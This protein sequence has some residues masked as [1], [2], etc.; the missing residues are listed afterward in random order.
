[1][2]ILFINTAAAMGGA[3]WSLL[4]LAGALRREGVAVLA[5]VPDGALA[6]RLRAAGV[7]TVRLPALCLRRGWRLPAAGVRL[8]VVAMRLA[9]LIRRERP[10][11]IHAN[12]LA[13]ALAL[14]ATRTRVPWLW[15]VRDLSLPVWALRLTARPA[16]ALIAI[17]PAVAQR[18]RDGLPDALQSRIVT[19]LNG[20]ELARLPE[21]HDR[22][23]ARR[24]LGLP[25]EGP[26]IG[27]IAHLAP[28]KR[29]ALFLE[30]AARIRR[31]LPAA[32]FVLAGA[33]VQGTQRRLRRRLLARGHE[34]GLDTSTLW[35]ENV[36]PV[37]D[38]LAALDVLV[39]PAE[40]EPFGRV[41][42]EAMAVGTP[43][44]A[45]DGAGPGDLIASGRSGLLVPPGDAAALAAAVAGLVAD[46]ATRRQLTA[47]AAVEVRQRCD[48]TRVVGEV[49]ALYQSIRY[50]LSRGAVIS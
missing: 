3:E 4:E 38:L 18:L 44:V 2:R 49:L 16:R 32:R 15:H 14:V 40:T 22:A 50:L 13:A 1:M 35:L 45:A 9:A 41:L 19:I 30:A 42:C 26:L 37:A 6:L 7:E 24:R 46:D 8:A 33:D 17:S 34:L 29:H 25:P 20:V 28:W 39:H 11:L 43:V 21:A 48:L 5:A 10:E 31:R 12:S 23:A 27:M 36:E 47:A